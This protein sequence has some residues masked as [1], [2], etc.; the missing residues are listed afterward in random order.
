MPMLAIACGLG[1]TLSPTTAP[2]P[3]S[4]AALAANSMANPAAS[5]TTV[6]APASITPPPG[7]KLSK[8]VSGACQVAAPPDWQLGSDFFLE[9]ESADSGFMATKTGEYPHMGLAL[10]QGNKSTPLPKGKWFQLR[11]SL[12]RG[13]QVCSVWRIKQTTDFTADEKST[14]AQVGKTLQEVH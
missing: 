14:M 4:K 10:W 6:P 7:W 1:A 9:V 11:R 3:T 8:D 2:A 12:V 13:Q 5:S